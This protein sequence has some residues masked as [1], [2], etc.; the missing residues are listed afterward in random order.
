MYTCNSVY[1][2]NLSDMIDGR[3]SSA[4]DITHAEPMHALYTTIAIAWFSNIINIIILYYINCN[5]IYNTISIYLIKLVAC[6]HQYLWLI[7][8]LFL[9]LFACFIIYY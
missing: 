3:T 4:I 8:C 6:L 5:V 2:V 9:L 7:L 1:L